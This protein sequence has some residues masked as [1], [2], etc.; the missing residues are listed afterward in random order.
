MLMHEKPCLIPILML[1]YVWLSLPLQVLEVH[2]QLERPLT[3]VGE[4][5]LDDKEKA[6]VREMCNVS[7]LTLAMLNKLRRYAHF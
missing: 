3:A 6:I 4:E 2:E 1:E 5:N 7:I